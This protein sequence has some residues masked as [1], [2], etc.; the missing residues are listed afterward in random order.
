MLILHNTKSKL[1]LYLGLQIKK[2]SAVFIMPRCTCAAKA[3][4]SL[5]VFLSFCHSVILSVCYQDSGS[6]HAI[7]VLKLHKW[8]QSHVIS[9][10]NWLDF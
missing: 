5:L 1:L 6:M 7:Q 9:D 10:L 3:Y 2:G 4:G 8:V